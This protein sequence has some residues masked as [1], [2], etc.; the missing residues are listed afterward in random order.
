MHIFMKDVRHLWPGI[1]VVLTFT[2]AFA[3]AGAVS[4]GAFG[5]LPDPYPTLTALTLPLG[6]A[7]LIAAV[8]HQEA[9]PGHHQYWLTRPYSW[10]SL[11]VAKALFIVS[12]INVPKLLA[13]FVILEG[14]G[15]QAA[16]YWS[17]FIASQLLFT[18]VWLLPYSA[19]AA[20]TSNLRQFVLAVLIV[21]VLLILPS[22]FLAR[23][24]DLL[25]RGFW[26]GAVWMQNFM[27]IGI[28]LTASLV[29][30][31]WQY[32][33]RRTAL[34]RVI[35]LCAMILVLAVPNLISMRALM[36]AQMRLS[37]SRMDVPA[38]QAVLDS[39]RKEP[40]TK[41][42]G[43]RPGY[44]GTIAIGIPLQISGL[45]AGTSMF[46]DDV[47]VEI[48]EPDGEVSVATGTIEQEVDGV[49]ERLFVRPDVFQ[50][51]KEEQVTL[52]HSAY[53]SLLGDPRTTQI[54]PGER[55]T[56]VPD[57]GI[58]R[59]VRQGSD[60]TIVCFTPFRRSPV[61]A[62]TSIP[63]FG[64]GDDPEPASYSP[65]PAEPGISPLVTSAR[66]NGATEFQG[67]LMPRVVTK[68]AFA[69]IRHDFEIRGLRL[70]DCAL[71][72]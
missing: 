23:P 24:S 62:S 71:R 61:F 66:V 69:H 31:L 5:Q 44:E 48:E 64:Y 72:D 63:D 67:S 36:A 2:A 1:L 3:Y 29:I 13:D 11:L 70:E 35:A 34:S 52:R 10:K 58:C 41:Q 19:L 6:W 22:L 14:Q 59:F 4:P 54:E 37:K 27:I 8:I 46:F 15:F 7:Y 26:F 28:F 30:L 65:F 32:S 38:I 40:K 16:S 50:R 51:L 47:K 20:V 55:G 68:S 18:A 53:L 21:W 25:S 9:L 56:V 60:Y 49:W 39:T 42:T 45:P 33:R 17:G 43:R 57:L 12:F